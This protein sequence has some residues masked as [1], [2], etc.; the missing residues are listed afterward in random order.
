M[1]LCWLPLWMTIGAAFLQAEPI[2]L[3][4]WE[5]PANNQRAPFQVGSRFKEARIWIRGVECARHYFDEFLPAVFDR[6]L[7]L[8]EMDLAGGE[9]EWIFT[10]PR[11]GVTV[12][13]GPQAVEVQQRYYDSFGFA[14]LEDGKV[15][16][17]RY[18]QKPW[19]TGKVEYRNRLSAVGIVL[20]HRLGLSLM[21]NG[22]EV[23]RQECVID[24]HRHQLRLTN[25]Q[26]VACGGLSSPTPVEVE[27][28]V[29]TG[30]RYQTMIGFGGSPSIPAYHE[31]SPK[32]KEQWWKLLAEYNLL[33]H[34]EYP[35]CNRL[36]DNLD[37]FDRLADATP[38]YYGDNFPNGEISDFDY[39]KRHYQMG[40]KVFFEF[41]AIPPMAR[42]KEAKPYVPNVEVAHPRRY[43]QA[44]MR[45]C[46]LSRE[47]AGALPDVIG[48]QNEQPQSPEVW[49]DI[50]LHLRQELDR[51]G[52]HSVRLHMADAGHVERGLEF[53]KGFLKYPES[54][55]HIDYSAVHMYDYQNHFSDPD[56]FDTLLKR[57][58]ELVGSKPFLS[59]E[60][61]VNNSPYQQD[62]YRLALSMGQLYHKNLVICNAVAVCYCWTLLTVEQP[63]FGWTRSLF[64]PDR[65]QSFTPVP[66]SQ[67]LRVFGAYSRRIHEGMVRVEAGAPPNLLAAAFTG[68]QDACTVVLL[69]RSTVPMKADIKGLNKRF[70]YVECVD[71]YQENEPN[72]VLTLDDGRV[73]VPPGAIVTLSN[74][75]LGSESI[76]NNQP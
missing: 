46:E 60:L 72:P 32:G 43:V 37:N 35:N 4:A 47:R 64:V 68:Q 70:P 39:L 29:D 42:N 59:T 11:G 30:R 49:R 8:D 12:R 58:N 63:S 28:R 38:H 33:I 13:I 76:K 25:A 51:A 55:E 41:W 6:C 34:R 36:N 9:L 52:Y 23:L 56:G 54:W 48:I 2:E 44:I 20:D 53:A 7:L 57:W 26:A 74:V 65:R 3:P 14:E 22:R 69:N 17:H 18:E 27:V 15:K 67:Q 40:G 31:L 1:R 62:S 5:T 24:L 16:A 19:H 61:C 21:L 71:P 66:A 75:R 50:V 45:F 73:C 10:G